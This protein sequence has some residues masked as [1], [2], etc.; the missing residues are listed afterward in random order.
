[1]SRSDDAAVWSI[2]QSADRSAGTPEAR[3]SN[4]AWVS[5]VDPVLVTWSRSRLMP[6]MFH[7]AIGLPRR[8]RWHYRNGP[9]GIASVE[10]PYRRL[11]GGVGAGVAL[12]HDTLDVLMS[13]HTVRPDRRRPL[14]PHG[15]GLPPP[16]GRRTPGYPPHLWRRRF[17][18]HPA[19]LP[20]CGPCLVRGVSGRPRVTRRGIHAVGPDRAGYVAADDDVAAPAGRF[21]GDV[22]LPDLGR[23]VEALEPDGGAARRHRQDVRAGHQRPSELPVGVEEVS[24][25]FWRTAG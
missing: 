14:L 12:D 25:A 3:T 2:L 16:G 11:P 9:A 7:G 1:M 15:T 19:P 5:V 23:S 8:S 21:T 24:D 13:A 6:V 4:H 22:V 10:H 20:Q 18:E 17:G